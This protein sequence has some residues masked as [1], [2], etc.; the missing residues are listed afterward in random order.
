MA[1]QGAVVEYTKALARALHAQD[2]RESASLLSV[3]FRTRKDR[4][5]QQIHLGEALALTNVLTPLIAHTHC[6]LGCRRFGR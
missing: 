1:G 5:R 3:I 4:Q 2:G 6:K